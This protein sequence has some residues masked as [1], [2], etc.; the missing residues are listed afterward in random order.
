MTDDE[1]G[2]LARSLSEGSHYMPH[3]YCLARQY[4][5]AAILIKSERGTA[6]NAAMI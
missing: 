5:L 2:N 6:H 1:G 4:F 3:I